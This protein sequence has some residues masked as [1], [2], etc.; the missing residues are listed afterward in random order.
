MESIFGGGIE[1]EN[2]REFVDF[3]KTMDKTEAL[4]ILEKA[5]DF[6][7][8]KDVFSVQETYFVYKSLKKLKQFDE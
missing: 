8:D 6:A 3:L 7:C 4:L 5:I 1:Y 2:E